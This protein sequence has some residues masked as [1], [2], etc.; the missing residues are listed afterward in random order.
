MSTCACPPKPRELVPT[1]RIRDSATSRGRVG[2]SRRPR[3]FETPRLPGREQ[4]LPGGNSLFQ[5]GNGLSLVEAAL[6]WQGTTPFPRWAAAAR[7]G[8]SPRQRAPELGGVALHLPHAG[9][10]GRGGVLQGLGGEGV[11]AGLEGEVGHGMKPSWTGSGSVGSS[12]HGVGQEGKLARVQVQLG[13]GARQVPGDVL[14]TDEVVSPMVVQGI[15]FRILPPGVGRASSQACIRLSERSLPSRLAI[16]ES[17]PPAGRPRRVRARAERRCDVRRPSRRASPGRRRGRRPGPEAL[18]AEGEVRG[19]PRSRAPG[20][21]P[22]E[23]GEGLGVGRATT[24]RRAVRGPATRGEA[25]RRE[26][27]RELQLSRP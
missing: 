12:G 16:W 26:L 8:R 21:P 5:V 19:R 17:L 13:G 23:R 15:V 9:G 7:S 24:P 11:A 14:G 2:P 18:G 3:E 10:V 1:R 27:L 22:R 25:G 6:P 4:P 20:G